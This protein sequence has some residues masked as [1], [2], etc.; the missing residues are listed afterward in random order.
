LFQLLLICIVAQL[1]AD[2]VTDMNVRSLAVGEPSPPIGLDA[3]YREHFASLMRLA[4][5]MLGSNDAAEDLV[6]EV[7]LRCAD[8]WSDLE[9]PASYLRVSVVNACRREFRRRARLTDVMA[10]VAEA[11]PTSGS[12][13]LRRALLALGPRKRAAVVLRFYED[14]SFDD[15]AGALG[16][17]P[18]TARSLVRRA[19]NEMRGALDE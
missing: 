5:L 1:S 11:A 12:V 13:D 14:M 9:N 8:R 4:F 7:F 19:M 15:V 10:E 6:H 17:A 2:L 18:S 16:C 3:V